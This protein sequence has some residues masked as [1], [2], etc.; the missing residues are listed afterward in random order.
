[1]FALESLQETLMIENNLTSLLSNLYIKERI[2][3]RV[4]KP[5]L[6]VPAYFEI[7]R[8]WW[9]N[10]STESFFEFLSKQPAISTLSGYK[11]FDYVTAS[12]ISILSPDESSSS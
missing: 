11:H 10:K 4:G 9:H 8:Y 7:N 12:V 2:N 1:M 6:S 5:Y 3:T